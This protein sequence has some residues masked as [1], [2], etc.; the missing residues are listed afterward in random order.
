MS[1]YGFVTGSVTST[2]LLCGPEELG[3]VG[4]LAAKLK[5]IE[6]LD[7]RTRHAEGNKVCH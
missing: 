5:E 2:L 7:E 4:D 3:G 1:I 6:H